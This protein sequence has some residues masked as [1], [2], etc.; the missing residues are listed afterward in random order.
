M[1]SVD[2]TEH[3]AKSFEG[4]AEPQ[5]SEPTKETAQDITE[6]TD[7]IIFI[8]DKDKDQQKKLTRQILFLLKKIS[9]LLQK[10]K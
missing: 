5:S 2:L 1:P 8:A 4:I 9:Q 3:K 7:K 6:N 10:T